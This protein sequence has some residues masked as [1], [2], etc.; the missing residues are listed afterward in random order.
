MK[1]TIFLSCTI[2]LFIHMRA[3]SIIGIE[4]E[5]ASYPT[6]PVTLMVP[7]PRGERAD[8]TARVVVQ[9][10]EKHLGQPTVAVNKPGTL[11][12]VRN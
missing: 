12:W 7:F 2:I 5:A 3:L 4:V 11:G 9:H 8:L 10:L 6:K 1:K